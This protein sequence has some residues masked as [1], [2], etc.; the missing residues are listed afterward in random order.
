[1]GTESRETCNTNERRKREE[2]KCIW[3]TGGRE[4]I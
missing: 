4:Q 1:M 2:Q 3:R